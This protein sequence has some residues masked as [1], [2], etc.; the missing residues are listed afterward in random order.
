MHR[1][2]GGIY[3]LLYGIFAI[4][5]NPPAVINKVEFKTWEK[6]FLWHHFDKN[7]IHLDPSKIDE[8]N[9]LPSSTNITE[10]KAIEIIIYI[11]LVIPRF[12]D[13]TAP[14]REPLKNPEN[15]WNSSH[16]RS[17]QKMKDPMISKWYS[18]ISI[19]LNIC[20]TSRCIQ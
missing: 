9:S 5:L 13:V 1:V 11:E 17:P 19:L 3:S 12:S 8:I 10:L 18:L 6:T 7:R 20:D 16:Q 15:N 14:I 2:F 4:I